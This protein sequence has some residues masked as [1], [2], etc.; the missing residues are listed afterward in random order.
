VT[1][2]RPEHL[3]T[4]AHRAGN[5]AADLRAALEAGV[6]LV[7]LD[8]HRYRG[9]LEVRHHK[10]AGPA[11][12][13]DAGTLVRR[14]GFPLVTLEEILAAAGTDP[15][16]M[17]DLKGI[18]PR[19]APQVAA[20]LR[21]RMPDLPVTVCSRHWW[22]LAAFAPPVRRILSARSRA[23]LVRLRRRLA[24]RRADGLSLHLDLLT[25]DLVA[26]LRKRADLVLTW[27]VDTGQALG[28]ARAVGVD[29]VISKNL[30]LL[31]AIVEAEGRR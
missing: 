13:Y 10:A 24:T 12:L 31:A 2:P 3:V 19:L 17:L 26:G 5:T 16:L 30:D 7:E 6:D 22:M 14:S 9:T 28:R 15:R 21:Q 20:L 18:P 25:P 4:V 8:V 11:H 1:A 23:D 29:G 27:P